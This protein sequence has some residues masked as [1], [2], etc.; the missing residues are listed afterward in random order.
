[1]LQRIADQVVEDTFDQAQVGLHSRQARPHVEPQAQRFAFSDEL[2][3]LHHVAGEF[4]ELEGLQLQRD[5][6]EVEL[7]QLEQLVD[8]CAQVFAL[9]QRGI[10][11]AASPRSASSSR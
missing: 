8:Q 9:A 3:L 7:G 1:M 4:G 10:Q 5:A 2:E 6:L 11:A